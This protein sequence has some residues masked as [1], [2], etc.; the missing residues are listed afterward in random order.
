MDI[1]IAVAATSMVSV[2]IFGYRLFRWRR[3][4][5]FLS[6]RV[7]SD[8]ELVEALYKKLL[9]LGLRVW[10]DKECLKPGQEWEDGFANG[11][12]TSTVFV[13]ILSKAALERFATLDDDSPC[14]NVMLEHL[15][16]LEWRKRGRMKGVFP[17]LVGALERGTTKHGHF[18]SGDGG[19]SN[20]PKGRNA[21]PSVD[22]KTLNHLQRLAAGGSSSSFGCV[23]RRN[24]KVELLVEERSPRGVL[25][26]LLAFQGGFVQGDRDDSLGYLAGIIYELVHDVAHGTTIS[27]A[28]DVEDGYPAPRAPNPPPMPWLLVRCFTACIAWLRQLVRGGEVKGEG[29][30]DGVGVRVE[31]GGG[32]SGDSSAEA[33]DAKM[34]GSDGSGADSN[35]S[36]SGLLAEKTLSR[37]FS[38]A[39]SK[40]DT[41]TGS[42]VNPVL[43]KRAQLQR[44][45]ERE[46]KQK[47][48]AAAGGAKTGGLKRLM[49]TTALPNEQ[50]LSPDAE[51][52]AYL[53]RCHGVSS[54]ASSSGVP[55]GGGLGSAARG[56][57]DDVHRDVVLEQA[58]QSKVLL[59]KET[60]AR[61]SRVRHARHG[62]TSNCSDASSES[63]NVERGSEGSSAGLGGKKATRNNWAFA[64]SRLKRRVSWHVISEEHG[65]GEEDDD[66]GGGGSAGGT[67]RSRRSS[68]RRDSRGHVDGVMPRGHGISVFEDRG[69]ASREVTIEGPASEPPLS[70]VERV[71]A[72]VAVMETTQEEECKQR[73]EAA[74]EERRRL[75]M[76]PRRVDVATI[77]F[78]ELK[79]LLAE[80]GMP[81]KRL[82]PAQNKHLLVAAAKEWGAEAQPGMSSVEA[83]PH[84]G[85]N[86]KFV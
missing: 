77:G 53:E 24:E 20:I 51:V 16:A 49:P 63:I 75:R 22:A 50:E 38:T 52:S 9:T 84:R 69:V 81:R 33:M 85:L 23:A 83:E 40:H 35:S 31:G 68:A 78:S 72:R 54:P 45:K 30:A 28:K 1:A 6:Y 47:S 36:A 86:L 59:R 14:D 56:S 80:R 4:S 19:V 48:A 3:I 70:K 37:F 66:D 11:L 17:I 13:P 61:L 71:S 39:V 73:E 58:M 7:A 5:V 27:E 25:D 65:K 57:G 15:L 79:R 44:Q 60:N 41:P 55:R 29:K 26:Q 12:F 34:L 76:Q 18:L 10:W 42:E 62:M 21:I 74:E 46:R 32:G 82:D 67:G 2:A 64:L 8:Q 43:V